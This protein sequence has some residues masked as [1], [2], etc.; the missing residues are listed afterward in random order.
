M[1]SRWCLNKCVWSLLRKMAGESA[2]LTLVG[3]SFHHW[4]TRTGKSMAIAPA[5]WCRGAQCSNLGMYSCSSVDGLEGQHHHLE[6]DASCKRKPVE[7]T[8]EGRNMG[9]FGYI[10]KK[11]CCSVLDTLLWF[12]HRGCESSQERVAVVQAGDDQHLDQELF[13]PDPSDVVECK[14][15][16]SGH[17]SDVGGA[18]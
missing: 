11:P 9:T 3:S 2:V 7:G 12:Y 16:W 10:E 15:A 14:S 8:E 13:W 18:G 5:S 4:G 17:S 6:S 1:R